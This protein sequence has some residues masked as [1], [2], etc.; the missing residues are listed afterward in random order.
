MS[1]KG[2]TIKKS[3]LNCYTQFDAEIKELNRGNAKF[4]NRKCSFEWRK[5]NPKIQKPN[6]VC[7]IC[8]KDF[9]RSASKIAA[10]KSG[11]V[12]CSRNCKDIA[13]RIG[14]IKE[15]HPPHYTDNRKDYRKTAKEHLEQICSHCG[16]DKHPEVLQVHHKDRNRENNSIE[17]LE[18]VCPTC[19]EVD[20][21]LSGDG[22]F[23]GG[24]DRN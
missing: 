4:C 22:R 12:F 21:F 13:Q 2:R 15:I 9:Y 14:G 23:S 20:H 6:C 3:C 11:F 5:K 10:S 24:T 7:A 19:H 8:D 1:Y 16:Y 18:I 17:N